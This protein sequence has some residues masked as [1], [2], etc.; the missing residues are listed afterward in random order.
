MH[1]HTTR[2]AAVILTAFVLTLFAVPTAALAAGNFEGAPWNRAGQAS[3]TQGISTSPGNRLRWDNVAVS[4]RPAALAAPPIEP[5]EPAANLE[6]IPGTSTELNTPAAEGCPML[7]RDGLQLYFASNRPGGLGEL[8]IWVAERAGPEEPFGTPVN[9]GAPINSPG[10]DFCPS[11]LRDGK[12]FLFVSNR[13]GGCGGTDIYLTRSHPQ[14]GWATPRNL[15]CTVNSSADE[16]GPVL[17]FAEAGPPALYFSS[18]RPS[19]LG[20]IN[21]YRSEKGRAWSFAAPE[22]VPGVNSDADDIQPYVRR[23]GRELVFASNRP[24]SQGFDIWSAGRDSSGDPWSTPV[25]LGPDIN[26]P[27]GETR[28]SLSWDGK[29]LLFGSNRPGVEGQTDLFFSTR[30]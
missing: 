17:V 4:Q 8:D 20:G 18:A 13:P 5:W 30:N 22:L 26:S 9:L 29:T 10:N 19:E 23:D 24:G 1:K 25:N 27:E 6:S 2:Q 15:G 21:L 3:G 28:P 14:N 7:S 12:G 11:P 16:A